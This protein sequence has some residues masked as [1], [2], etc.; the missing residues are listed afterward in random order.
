MNVMM[1]R[2]KTSFS[3]AILAALMTSC[4]NDLN[5]EPLNKQI[6]TSVSA[7]KDPASYKQFLAKLYGSLTLTGQTGPYGN[8]EIPNNDEGETS[9]LRMYWS[10]QETNTDECNLAWANPS[11]DELRYTR[12]SDQSD[13]NRLMYERIFINIAYCNEYLRQVKDRVGGLDEQ[14]KADVTVYLAEAR[15]LRALF[16]FYALDLWGNVPFVTEADGIG[17]YLPKQIKRADLFKFIESELID[18][19]PTLPAPGSNE[20]ARAS[21]GAAWTL[22]AKLYLNA[23]VYTGTAR[24]TDCITYCNKITAS[25]AY[26]LNPS[27]ANLFLAD[28]NILTNEIILPI[29]EDGLVSQNY[30]G[31]TFIVHASI[32][33]GGA[34]AMNPAAYGIDGGWAGTRLRKDFVQK[35]SD[36]TGATDKRAA[37]IYTN[38]RSLEI[39]HVTEYKEGYGCVKFKNITSTGANGQHPTFVDT[40]FPIFRLADVYLMYAEAVLRGGTGG[41]LN[42]AV[43][44]VNKVRERAYGNTTGNITSSDLTLDFILDERARELHWEAHRRTDLIRFGRFT[45]D[46]YLWE[47]KGQ[48][49]NGAGVDKH[50]DLFPIPASDLV[51]N[52]NLT[53]NPGY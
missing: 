33:A 34:D 13:Y 30:G 23:E 42:T 35:F 22:L 11:T 27:Y 32:I 7:F 52:N 39:D 8:P 41:D 24:Y 37:N 20:Y 18:V 45:G 40:D 51:I 38:S 4:F 17:G 14:L 49:K 36:L 21:Q 1:N 28:N 46:T 16:Y 44:L 26:S 53:Q 6:T 43:S 9:F 25:N 47:W 29:A 15:F 48:S 10:A 50:Y 12:S 19:I 2:Y 31:V 5:T 3:L